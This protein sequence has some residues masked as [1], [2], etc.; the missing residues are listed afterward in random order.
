VPG[1]YHAT[2]H[3]G[4]GIGLA[5][6]TAELL[7]ALIDGAAPPVDAAPFAPARFAAAGAGHPP[8]SFPPLSARRG[9]VP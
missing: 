5:P 6:A 7:T 8:G 4:A 1:L 3:E 9:D 2:G